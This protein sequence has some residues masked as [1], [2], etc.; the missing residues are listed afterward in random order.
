[1]SEPIIPISDPNRRW[2]TWSIDEIYT[3]SDGTGRYV[4]N[5]NDLVIDW[6]Q[7]IYKVEGVDYSTGLSRLVYWEIPQRNQY[8]GE[9][10][11]IGID[12]AAQGESYRVYIDGSV[13]PHTL[14]VDS[15]LHIYG[16]TASSIKLFRG[17]NIGMEGEV[18]SAMYDASGVFTGENIPL[19]LVAMPDQ[20][21]IAIKTPVVGYTLQAFQDGDV[22]TAVVYDDAGYAISYS[23]LLV[24]NTAFVR[25]TE[26][27]QRYVASIHLESPFLDS[28]DERLLRFPNNMAVEDVPIT[29]V[30][31]YND[32]S[33]QRYPV[34]GGQ[35]RL[36]G[37]DHFIASIV[38]QKVPLVLT[39]KLN[40]DES[41]FNGNSTNGQH[42]LS[43][44][45][46]A[47]TT[48]F[49]SAYSI[50]LFV[51]PSWQDDLRG[52]KLQFFLSNL[53]RT[54]FWNVTHAIR[55]SANSEAF[56][57]FLYGVRQTLEF[58]VNMNDVDRRY[59]DY[60]HVQSLDITLL[61]PGTANQTQW[62]VQYSPNQNPAYGSG[63]LVKQRFVNVN[64][65]EL[66]L[67][68]QLNSEEEWLRRVYED[69]EP[70]VHYERETLPPRPNYCLIKAGTKEY[71]IPTAL[72]DQPLVVSEPID[73][74]KTI[75]IEFVYRYY[76]NDL[77]LAIAAI[78]VYSM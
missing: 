53:E 26:A 9:D 78:P 1:M 2:S 14:A 57:P 73:T 42:H 38:G 72:W 48:A 5:K 11:L 60:Y 25:T 24:K 40:P 22:L 4:P 52:Y 63:L 15:R 75:L 50:K 30:V 44:N 70:L 10:K 46:W 16:T 20:H 49:E 23:K 55:M 18:V 36:Y 69:T 61:E 66:D 27:H 68:C 65:Y 34:D 17:T 59:P 43:E 76:E 28:A 77:K 62:V 31:T 21:N 39:Y 37:L 67:S 13:I 29:G 6:Q 56:R 12:I 74:G 41:C 45:Y 19:E 3:G 8:S 71:A 35:F 64:N 47:I 58:V 51:Y 33:Q 7:G 54:E 32:G